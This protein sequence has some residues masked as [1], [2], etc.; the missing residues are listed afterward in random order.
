[1]M[2]AKEQCLADALC[3]IDEMQARAFRQE[4]DLSRLRGVVQLLLTE[5]RLLAR[6]GGERGYRRMN[7][8]MNHGGD[9]AATKEE[10]EE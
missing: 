7:H 1:M 5:E 4:E 8:R 2:S 3:R 9:A 10:D 6:D